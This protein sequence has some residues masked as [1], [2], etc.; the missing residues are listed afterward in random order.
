MAKGFTLI[1]VLVAATLLGVGVAAVIGGIRS[2]NKA[3]GRARE[4]EVMQRLAVDKYD[5]IRATTDTYAAG[6]SGDF[7][8]K[9][10]DDYTWEMKVDSTG[11]ENVSAITVTVSKRDTDEGEPVGAVSGLVFEKPADTGTD[12]GATP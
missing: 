12:V 10:I 1:E 3:E 9:N 11:V 5:E 7:V 6:D 8:E 4:L 2:V